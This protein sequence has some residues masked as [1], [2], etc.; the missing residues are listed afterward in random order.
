MS[1]LVPNNHVSQMTHRYCR[2]N[3]SDRKTDYPENNNCLRI[4]IRLDAVME[5]SV[6]AIPPILLDDLAYIIK[7]SYK[8]QQNLMLFISEPLRLNNIQYNTIIRPIIN[9]W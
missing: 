8:I 3:N 4:A 1:A 9:R 2:K 7:H 6:S 5:W